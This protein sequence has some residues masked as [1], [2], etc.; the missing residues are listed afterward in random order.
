MHPPDPLDKVI[1]RHKLRAVRCIDF[2]ENK[3]GSCWYDSFACW[4]NEAKGKGNLDEHLLQQFPNARVTHQEVR[5]AICNYLLGDDCIV[6]ETWIE[7]RGSRIKE[8]VDFGDEKR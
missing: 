4:I 8:Q 1:K 3:S 2:E 6:K 5:A 7:D